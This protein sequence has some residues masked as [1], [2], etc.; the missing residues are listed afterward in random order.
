MRSKRIYVASSWRNQLQPGVVAA[1]RTAGHEVYDFRNPAPDDHGF[2]WRQLEHGDVKAWDTRAFR[3]ALAHPVARRGFSLDFEAM[4]WADEF[5]LVLPCGRS[6]H[7]EAG[8]AIGQGKRTSVFIETLDEP[9]LMYLTGGARTRICADFAEVLAFHD[10]A[11]AAT[12]TAVVG[13][14]EW[15]PAYRQEIVAKV[16]TLQ[17]NIARAYAERDEMRADLDVLRDWVQG[18]AGAATCAFCSPAVE[19]EKVA[20]MRNHVLACPKHPARE[21]RV[22]LL[23]DIADKVN[24]AKG[25]R[26]I[27]ADWDVVMAPVW[28]A[29]K[30]LHEE[31]TRG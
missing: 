10:E 5:C 24:D 23:E 7:L 29:L 14:I 30:K 15:C 19:P 21:L 1:L 17:E 20:A 31:V 27:G 25:G 13:E 28:A 4:K 3:H 2:S 16:Q 6:A 18:I 11:V 26:E 9:E 12:P 8:W 22:A